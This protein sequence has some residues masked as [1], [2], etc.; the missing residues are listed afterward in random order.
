MFHLRKRRGCHCPYG[1]D[2]FPFT[3]TEGALP[4]LDAT[5][6]QQNYSGILEESCSL[7]EGLKL[8]EKKT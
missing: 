1:E 4:E 5:D 3:L 6:P 7:A 2:I 8:F